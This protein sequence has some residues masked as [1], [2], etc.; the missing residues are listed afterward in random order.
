MEMYD[1]GQDMFHM[2]YRVYIEGIQ[3]PFESVSITTIYK[4]APS[5]TITMPPWPGLNELGRNYNPKV[6]IFWKDFNTAVST[7]DIPNL[8]E[9]ARDDIRD[10][11]KLIYSGIVS[12]TSESKNISAE[13]ASQ[14]I[15][16]TCN[17]P[18]YVMREILIRYT[19]QAIS[20]AQS[21]LAVNADSSNT[22]ASWDINGLMIKAL[23]GV[24]K[25]TV[26]NDSYYYVEDG[27][28]EELQGT[29]G[30]LRVM[31]NVLKRDVIRN[32]GEGSTTILSDIYIPLIE[33][34]LK[35]WERLT[36]HPSIEGDIQDESNRVDYNTNQDTD[37]TKG[38]DT[39]APDKLMIP[40]VFKSF[41]GDAAQKEL[42]LAALRS[43]QAGAGSPESSNFYDHIIG[44]LDRLE[45]DMLVL[46]S[47][48]STSDYSIREYIVKPR[49]TYY[50]AP[51]CN[52]LLPNILDSV[53]ISNGYDRIPS[54]SVNLSNVVASVTGSYTG[55]APTQAYISPHSV[56]YARA[57][58]PSG[59]LAASLSSTANIPGRYEYGS[60]VR[61]SVIQLPSMYN[62]M[63]TYLDKQDIEKGEVGAAL[64]DTNYTN[65]L[66]YWDA[67]YPET[68]WKNGDGYNPLS[69]TADI[70]SFNRLNFMYADQKFATET[71]KARTA[72]ASSLFNPYAIVGYPMDIVDPAPSR[73]SYHGL[74]TSITH[75]IHAS[76]QA[77]TSYSVSAV[78]SFSELAYYKVPSVNPYLSS[79]FKFVEDSRL[80]LNATAY[81]KA[82]EVYM[83]VLGVGAAEPALLQSHETGTPVPFT[84]P[85]KTGYWANGNGELYSTIRGSYKLI[86]R[87][88]TTL[89]ELEQ[90]RLKDNLSPFIDIDSWVDADSTGVIAVPNVTNI[91]LS[92]DRTKI[93]TPG[94]DTESSPFLDYLDT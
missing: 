37:T 65:T 76:G 31:W 57:G 44:L 72:Q 50:Y 34:G 3:V 23:N 17:H 35:F 40:A 21:Q 36:G 22:V 49:L 54:R 1:N 5:A 2:D 13:G 85:D 38:I 94:R 51:I 24:S 29:P 86:A 60:G 75:V 14:T 7:G 28:Y 88:I 32:K 89:H 46:N 19:N 67:Q 25:D 33:D 52:V 68:L 56:R 59:N 84:R 74:C 82:C 10:S 30:M 62:V 16:L 43:L 55:A 18:I 61:A 6:H 73:E 80:Y 90:E 9:S 27:K 48:V 78:S 63:K 47:P 69:Q 70:S 11:Y 66:L 93:I 64:D 87:D 79:V 91:E 58:G 12:G 39:D 20:A 71:A 92:S 41:L 42:T 77:S 26:D 4:E 81:A 83:E 8:G 45:Y 53:Q 15:T